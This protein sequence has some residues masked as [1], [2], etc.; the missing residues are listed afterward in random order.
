MPVR[1]KLVE[2]RP[3]RGGER[4]VTLYVKGFLG[5]G[6]KPDHF[7]RWLACHD[8]LV[9][10][11]GWGVAALGYYWQS[12]R[13]FPGPVA[14]VGTAKLAVDFVRVLRNL[15]RAARLGF[16]HLAIAGIAALRCDQAQR[17]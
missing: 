12:G 16:G 1:G 4:E 8:T 3:E 2:L 7:G 17:G 6:E 9:E 15:R 10:S 14:A 5:R 13:L 11:H